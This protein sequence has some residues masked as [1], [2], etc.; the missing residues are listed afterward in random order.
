MERT[1]SLDRKKKI[2]LLLRKIPQKFTIK[3]ICNLQKY[4]RNSARS[5]LDTLVSQKKVACTSN[6]KESRKGEYYALT[7]IDLYA[8]MAASLPVDRELAKHVGYNL[9]ANLYAGMSFSEKS[10]L[11]EIVLN[12]LDLYPFIDYE[13]TKTGEI[14]LQTKFQMKIVDA[15]TMLVGIVPCLCNN[16]HRPNACAMVTGALNFAVAQFTSRI[17][18]IAVENKQQ[19]TCRFKI[20]M[21]KS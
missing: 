18:R 5:T 10:N 9:T 8:K 19:A 1:K 17:V 7:P 20:T 3:E 12:A 11:Q 15:N 13:F 21:P 4:N 14:A 16:T 6:P 2:Q